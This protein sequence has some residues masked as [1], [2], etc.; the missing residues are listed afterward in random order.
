MQSSSLA[1]AVRRSSPRE[2]KPNVTLVDL[3]EARRQPTME[4]QAMRAAAMAEL[5]AERAALA[6]EALRAHAPYAE[7]L[8]H[9]GLPDGGR[10]I[11]LSGE[12][13]DDEFRTTVAT[14]LTAD[15]GPI[16]SPYNSDFW[17]VRFKLFPKPLFFFSN[18]KARP[19]LFFSA[20]ATFLF[21]R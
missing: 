2:R 9:E 10:A 4:E 17:K 18:A 6:D 15:G 5:R 12:G 14:L 21:R 8:P 3:G 7:E 1:P 20:A 11:V 13:W 16:P 19:S